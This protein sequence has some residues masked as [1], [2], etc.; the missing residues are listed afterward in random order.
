MDC[1]PRWI[2]QGWEAWIVFAFAI[3]PFFFWK[4][5]PEIRKTNIRNHFQLCFPFGVFSCVFLDV[6]CFFRW[7]SCVFMCGVCY[8]FVSFSCWEWL[9]K[10][11]T[12]SI[13]VFWDFFWLFL[14]F[15]CIRV[16]CFISRTADYPLLAPHRICL[17]FEA[18]RIT[19][20]P[21]VFPV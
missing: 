19:F 6:Q 21:R 2:P 3:N 1:V 5:A 18:I 14:L 9:E 20:F 7:F 10:H 16:Y 13:F 4:K 17:H 11:R 8:F 15:V 12:N